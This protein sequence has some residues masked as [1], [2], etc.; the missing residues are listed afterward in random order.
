VTVENNTF[1]GIVWYGRAPRKNCTNGRIGNICHDVASVATAT[2]ATNCRQPLIEH[3][4]A[5]RSGTA[6]G[7][8]N[9]NK[10]PLLSI[11]TGGLASG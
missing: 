9:A 1:A 6:G 5:F 11:P 10:D 3:N 2:A 4:L 7:E 8:K